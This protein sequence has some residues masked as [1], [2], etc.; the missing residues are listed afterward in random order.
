MINIILTNIFFIL[1]IIPIEIF[2]ILIFIGFATDIQ[3]VTGKV[4]VWIIPI[5]FL[6]LFILL[7]TAYFMS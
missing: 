6:A 2:T 7:D 3:N 1:F 4:G 5:L